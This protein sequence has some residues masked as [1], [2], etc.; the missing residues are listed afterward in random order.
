MELAQVGGMVVKERTGFSSD[1]DTHTP[2]HLGKRG[3]GSPDCYFG[4]RAQL[5]LTADQSLVREPPTRT[6]PPDLGVRD[7]QSLGYA[8]ALIPLSDAK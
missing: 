1:L 8:P 2:D 7:F 5:L 4:F 3:T 6:A